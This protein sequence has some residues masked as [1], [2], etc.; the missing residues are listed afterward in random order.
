MA[1]SFRTQRLDRRAARRVAAPHRRSAQEATLAEH[2]R[3]QAPCGASRADD[4][5]EPARALPRII[6]SPARSGHVHPLEPGLLRAALLALGPTATYGVQSIALRHRSDRRAGALVFGMLEVPGRIVLYEQPLPPWRFTG[7]LAPWQ[8]DLLASFGAV[9]DYNP[10]LDRSSIDW[11][12]SALRRFMLSQV[13]LH[14]LGHHQLQ[15]HKGKRT[16]RIARRR[17]HEA[18]AEQWAARWRPR[19][20]ALLDAS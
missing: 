14:E 9:I 13:L 4:V 17:D 19:L 15:H 11:P 18:H 1:R 2:R 12:P 6:V 7:A 10:M 16:I 5:P 20:Q 8:R 3:R